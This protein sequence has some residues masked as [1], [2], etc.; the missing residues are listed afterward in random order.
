MCFPGLPLSIPTFG[1][2]SSITGLDVTHIKEMD[3][4]EVCGDLHVDGLMRTLADA[5]SAP[6]GDDSAK[7]AMRKMF[8]NPAG[9]ISAIRNLAGA[10]TSNTS[11]KR[12]VHAA[13][14]L[15]RLNGLLWTMG[16]LTLLIGVYL[17]CCWPCTNIFALVMR[18]CCCCFGIEGIR[19]RRERQ[20]AR[21]RYYG[22][23]SESESESES[24]Q[25]LFKKGAPADQDVRTV[26]TP[27]EHESKSKSKLATA[28][29][30][31][32][33]GGKQ[34]KHATSTATGLLVPQRAPQLRPPA[35]NTQKH[36]P[37]TVHHAKN[38]VHKEHK[39]Q[40]VVA[41]SLHGAALDF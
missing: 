10:A 8:L 6:L 31:Q 30:A 41:G 13:C 25:P 4:G 9:A 1:N 36:T 27:T 22:I 37:A 26:V 32:T 39:Q 35:K 38:A 28:Q 23:E 5:F 19:W 3:F 11:Q 20:R 14:A 12:T 2:F 34:A 18:F 29:A 24:L 21:R 16:F 17:G 33:A 7:I 40:L 15:A